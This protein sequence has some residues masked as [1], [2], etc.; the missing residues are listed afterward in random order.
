[1]SPDA[2]K[3]FRIKM[4]LSQY[5]LMRLETWNDTRI[6]LFLLN[7]TNKQIYTI[8][9]FF[10]FWVDDNHFCINKVL[11]DFERTIIA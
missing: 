4:N 11:E 5:M 1:M 7:I 8:K 6:L 10:F 3:K 9:V 2:I